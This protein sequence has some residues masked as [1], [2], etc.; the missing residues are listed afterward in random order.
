MVANQ[1]E[2][3]ER[4]DC[5]SDGSFEPLQC[6]PGAGGLLNCVCVDPSTGDPI[7][8][9]AVTVADVNDAPECDRLG[10]C[11]LYIVQWCIN[12]CVYVNTSVCLC[13]CVCCKLLSNQVQ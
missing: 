10:E 2:G 9:T 5:A 6:Q 11:V 13:M 8:N 7:E 1:R 4:F 12:V 3:N